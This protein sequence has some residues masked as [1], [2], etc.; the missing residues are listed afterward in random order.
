MF[1]NSSSGCVKRRKTSR[2]VRMVHIPAVI[3]E[4]ERGWSKK[5]RNL[6]KKA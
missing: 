1:K 5:R 2:E 4:G 6:N 3:A